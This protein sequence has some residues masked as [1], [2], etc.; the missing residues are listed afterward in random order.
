VPLQ[1]HQEA[2]RCALVQL[3]RGRNL[4]QAERRLAFAKQI[5]YGECAVESLNFV[6]PL[7]KSVSQIDPLFQFPSL[8][9]ASHMMRHGS[10]GGTAMVRRELR[11]DE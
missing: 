4:R 5:E 1:N 7:W 10:T 8:T 2:M 6:S 11:G 3:Q 9:L